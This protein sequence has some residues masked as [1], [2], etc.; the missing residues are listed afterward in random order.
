MANSYYERINEYLPRT[1]AVGEQ[2]REDYEGVETGFGKLPVHNGNATGFTASFVVEN[3]TQN[4]SPVPYHQ[5]VAWPQA[6][7]AS[8]F[9]LTNLASAVQN[10]HAASLGD[11]KSHVYGWQQSVSANQFRLA[12]LRDPV[13]DQDGVNRQYL[14]NYVNEHVS[15][16]VPDGGIS[17]SAPI[18]EGG[19][20][21]LNPPFIFD[22]AA[23]HINGVVQE[24][25]RGAFSISNSTIRLS[26]PLEQ[27]DEVQVIIGRLTPPGN[28]EWTLISEDTETRNGHKLLLDSSSH[29]FTVTLPSGPLDS[30]RIDFLDVGNSLSINPVI[31]ARNGS[32]IMGEDE[33]LELR[34]N[35]VS[36][37]LLFCGIEY[38]WRI[39]E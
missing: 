26:R 27:G 30:D 17:W 22:L 11:V 2:V 33:D 20:T 15:P 35:L 31:I 28:S 25:T 3:P 16:D 37:A 32:L 5:F 23:V 24:Q 8:G 34:T 9:H 6:I 18:A 38:G 36:M 12:D 7:S 21:L 10:D 1:R 39:I 29:N 4:Q 14:V 13:L 19:E